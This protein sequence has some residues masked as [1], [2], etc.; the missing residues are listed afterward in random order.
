MTYLALAF[1]TGRLSSSELQILKLL[2]FFAE[3]KSLLDSVFQTPLV[4]F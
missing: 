4:V 3:I 1:L 2:F